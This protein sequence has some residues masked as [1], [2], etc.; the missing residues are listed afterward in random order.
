MFCK[1]HAF[2]Q[3]HRYLLPLGILLVAATAAATLLIHT[4]PQN[5]S[6]P[7][8]AHLGAFSRIDPRITRE[9]LKRPTFTHAV[10]LYSVVPGGVYSVQELKDARIR[11]QVVAA[12]YSGFDLGHLRTTRLDH[13]KTAY[14]SY[15]L[16]NEIFWTRKKL[17]LAKGELIITDG[18]RRV[19]ARCGNMVSDK[20]QPQTSLLEPDE[21]ALDEARG[22]D[23]KD[24]T[25][26]HAAV[27]PLAD[28]ADVFPD[29]LSLIPD[30]DPSGNLATET[31]PASGGGGPPILLLPPPGGSP[32]PTPAPVQEPA[33]LLLLSSGLGGA[34]LLSRSKCD[35]KGSTDHR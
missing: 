22:R 20:P 30:A 23:S 18:A 19:R 16:G 26:P 25:E 1:R 7:A 17:H 13:A 24:P 27:S 5:N 34:L 9:I 29:L 21:T 33:T 28:F 2:S 6:H 15:R 11:D 31:S 14:V 8:S 12:H 32:Q 4:S 10:Y 3:Y 35:G